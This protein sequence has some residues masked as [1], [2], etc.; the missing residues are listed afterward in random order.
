MEFTETWGKKY[1]AIVRLWEE[2]WAEFV[3]FPAFDAEIR[4]IISI[5]SAIESLNARLRRAVRARGHF[6]TEQAALKCLY[7]ALIALD[8]TGT[9]KARWAKRWK[10]ALHAFEITFEGRLIRT[11]G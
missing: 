1:P 9:A 11:T 5:T 7:L 8:P 10:P 3:P 4:T 6:P 2:A